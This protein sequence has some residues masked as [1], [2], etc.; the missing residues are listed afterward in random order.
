[1][2]FRGDKTYLFLNTGMT[3]SV[4]TDAIDYRNM[5]LKRP[6]FPYGF[7]VDGIT[8]Q[9]IEQVEVKTGP[10]QEELRAQWNTASQTAVA[11]RPAGS[12]GKGQ[13]VHIVNTN[14]FSTTVIVQDKT[15]N[16]YRRILLSGE[17]FEE[18][19][20]LQTTKKAQAKTKIEKPAPVKEVRD[21]E[22]VQLITEAP[23][24]IAP[25]KPSAPS[26][27]IPLAMS[28][29]LLAIG[30]TAT[31]LLSSTQRRKGAKKK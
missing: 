6:N 25:P 22:P 24:K 10:T 27:W 30:F 7:S 26:I 1:M 20:E 14:S 8:V 11:I 12:I 18:N 17:I 13:T 19:F 9:E 3:T 15:T 21:P 5:A 29:G 28:F 2:E 23:K 31:I 4:R 16:S